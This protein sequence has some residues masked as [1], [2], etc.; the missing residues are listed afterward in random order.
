MTT[1]IQARTILE[2][3]GNEDA[4]WEIAK[5]DEGL[6]PTCTKADWL[7]IAYRGIETERANARAYAS[8]DFG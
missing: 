8:L 2:T 4:A 1:Y 7:K 5:T 3:T 6:L